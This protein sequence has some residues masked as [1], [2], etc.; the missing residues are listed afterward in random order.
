MT[1]ASTAATAPINF[2]R[3]SMFTHPVPSLPKKRARRPGRWRLMP[4]WPF[5]TRRPRC[6]RRRTSAMEPA[7]ASSLD[8]SARSIAGSETEEEQKERAD[9]RRGCLDGLLQTRWRMKPRPRGWM[10]P[11]A[12]ADTRLC[13]FG[14]DRQR[15]PLM[16]S[17]FGVLTWYQ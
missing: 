6:T 7:S 3:A 1:T 5:S 10:R 9:A 8:T 11:W 14:M 13:A 16:K 2:L 17:C 12:P 4:A 15:W